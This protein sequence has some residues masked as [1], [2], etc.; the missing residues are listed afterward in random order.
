[1]PYVPGG[2]GYLYGCKG[3]G[4][5]FL[6]FFVFFLGGGT[7]VVDLLVGAAVAE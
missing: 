2:G 1:M 4:I 7:V 6:D 5:P 3:G